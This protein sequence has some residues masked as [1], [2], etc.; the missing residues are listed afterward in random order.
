MKDGTIKNIQFDAVFVSIGRELNIE[1]LQLANAGIQVKEGKIVADEYLRTTNK[2]V[3]VCGDVAGDLKFSHA[4][5]FH[6]RILLNNFF[7][8]FNKKLNNDHLSWVT[9]TDPE[10]ASFGLNEQQ[11][12]ERKIEYERLEQDFEDDDRAITD[13]YRY[14]KLVLFISS[15]GLLKKQKVLGGTMV[16]PNAGE[17]IQ[18]L[19]LA[20]TRGMSINSIFN[21][22]YPYP[23]ATRINQ[24]AIV[25]YKQQSLTE[26]IKK[27]LRFAYK[28]FS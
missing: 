25:Q 13:D 28:I 10:V 24:K 1:T 5:E 6:A 16:A 21:K 3:F 22:I 19:I 23:V 7:S 8:P 2:Q 15:K 11:L 27:L 26:G 17:L 12:K 20:N 14:G 18:E 4:A 9:F